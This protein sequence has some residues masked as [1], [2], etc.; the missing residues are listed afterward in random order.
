MSSAP[1]NPTTRFRAARQDG[2]TS[3]YD[4]P[5]ESSRSNITTQQHE[6]N[7][8]SLTTPLG[9]ITLDPS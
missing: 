7:D 2:G 4:L 3:V 9:S 5:R 6:S 1:L 8:T